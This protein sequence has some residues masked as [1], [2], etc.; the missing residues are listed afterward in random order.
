[1]KVVSL[2]F[3]GRLAV[4]QMA[5]LG[6]AECMW[7]QGVAVDGVEGQ[8]RIMHVVQLHQGETGGMVVRCSLGLHGLPAPLCGR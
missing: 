3:D 1:M 8:A 2:S 4:E 5:D 7:A 6:V